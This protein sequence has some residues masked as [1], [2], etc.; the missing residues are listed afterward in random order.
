[1]DPL[2]PNEDS[3]SEDEGAEE[4]A[5]PP[6]VPVADRQMINGPLTDRELGQ[7]SHGAEAEQEDGQR[8]Q[9]RT[10][11][12]EDRE[13]DRRR[14]TRDARNE[15]RRKRGRE[16]EEEE[17][18]SERRDH[19]SLQKKRIP[20]PEN[21][22]I[23]PGASSSTS[24]LGADA[25]Y[26]EGE[27]D[28]MDGGGTQPSK[29]LADAQEPAWRPR[30]RLRE[31]TAASEG[32]GERERGAP[33]EEEHEARGQK[34]PREDNGR[35]KARCSNAQRR[36]EGEHS[37]LLTG[38]L[39]WCVRC[40]YYAIRR[41]GTGLQ[42]SCLGKPTPGNEVRLERLRRHLHPVTGHPLR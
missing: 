17:D 42:R 33:A 6:D 4:P 36:W 3:G 5:A 40:G 28:E 32:G 7:K 22:E 8:A 13:E 10:L 14:R 16:E 21:N 39:I 2:W 38:P 25:R 34:R 11:A 30:R 15:E 19:E 23:T 29:R 20:G 27:D 31:K 26:G 12:A 1:M 37:L 18:K 24:P 9:E 41:Y 35:S